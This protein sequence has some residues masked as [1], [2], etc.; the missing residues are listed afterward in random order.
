MRTTKARF[1]L[2]IRTAYYRYKT[3]ILYVFLAELS[4]QLQETDSKILFTT[5]DVA[6]KGK[7]AAKFSASV[8]VSDVV[9]VFLYFMC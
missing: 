3:Q 9:C 4:L 2:R 1:C 8:K 5:P 6:A 7:E